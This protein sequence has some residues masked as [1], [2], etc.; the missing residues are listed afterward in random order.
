MRCAFTAVAK[1]F[2]GS[3]PWVYVEVPKKIESKVRV[4]VGT[5]AGKGWRFVPISVSIRTTQWKT[6]LL[7]LGNNAGYFIALKSD[8]RRREQITVGDKVSLSF[9]F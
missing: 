7:P 3:V 2:T 4:S 5:H 1:Q 9:T 6:S 8:V